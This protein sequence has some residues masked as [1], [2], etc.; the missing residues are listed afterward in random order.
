MSLW[1]KGNLGFS[2]VE[3]KEIGGVAEGLGV[4]LPERTLAEN[5]TNPGES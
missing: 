4:H 5:E 3:A 1:S 2:D